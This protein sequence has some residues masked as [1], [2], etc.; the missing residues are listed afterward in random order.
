MAIETLRA[1]KLQSGLT[2]LGVVIGTA[3]STFVAHL[4][5]DSLGTGA[6]G[7]ITRH[8]PLINGLAASVPAQGITT[9]ATAAS[10]FC[11]WKRAAPPSVSGTSSTVDRSKGRAAFEEM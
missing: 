6:G 7:R 1:N 10:V 4:F 11:T 8:L 2:V 9:L 3:L 5:A